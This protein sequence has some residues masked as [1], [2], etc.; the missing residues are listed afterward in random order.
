MPS[1][2]SIK[3]LCRSFGLASWL[4]SVLTLS[5]PNLHSA[6]APLTVMNL[7][8][9]HPISLQSAPAN[10]LRVPS[11]PFSSNSFTVL[12]IHRSKNVKHSAGNLICARDS[13]LLMLD[14]ERS[15]LC[16]RCCFGQGAQGRDDMVPE[17]S[18]E[19]TQSSD[20]DDDDDN[21]SQRRLGFFP[22]R[23]SDPT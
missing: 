13:S 1:V 10:V 22:V 9:P 5:V 11:F 21:N 19:R 7:S 4:L 2:S 15:S 17:P 3:L 18:P 20:D 23:P 12:P 16:C 8:S 6:S 14:G